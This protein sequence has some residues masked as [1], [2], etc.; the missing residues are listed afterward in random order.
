MAAL[1]EDGKLVTCDID[2]VVTEI[3]KKY[4]CR[5]PHGR[6]IELKLDSAL[7]TLKTI[8]DVF[9]LVF[10]D[11]DKENYIIY[12]ELCMPKTHSGSL[13]IIDNVSLER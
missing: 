9:D 2:P 8:D 4:W 3:A 1:P 12:W 6:K 13:F 11:A 7:E 10:I 5:S